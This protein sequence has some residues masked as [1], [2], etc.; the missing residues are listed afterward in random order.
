MELEERLERAYEDMV[1]ALEGAIE[2]LLEAHKRVNESCFGERVPKVVAPV[3]KRA[4]KKK[5]DR[6]LRRALPSIGFRYDGLNVLRGNY[7]KVEAD[8]ETA[9]GLASGADF[10]PDLVLEKVRALEETASELLQ[11]LEDAQQLALRVGRRCLEKES[12]R[13]LSRRASLKRMQ[14]M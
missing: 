1:L 12:M 5:V 9:R 8:R 2:R 7:K 6:I 4:L 10:S 13:E 3:F 14:K 11:A